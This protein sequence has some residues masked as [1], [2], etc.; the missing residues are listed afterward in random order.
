YHATLR[1]TWPAILPF[2]FVLPLTAFTYTSR[3]G[4]WVL[5]VL[6]LVLLYGLFFVAASELVFWNEF[7]VRFN[8]I[9][10]DYLVYTNEVIG[11]I[12]ESYPIGRWLALLVAGAL[13]VFAIGRRGLRARDDGSRFWQRGR[14]AL[15]WLVLTVAS[16]AVNGGMKDRT[17]N[18]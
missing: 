1:T 7:S 13:V 18:N 12:R 6:A 15:L 10:V 4:Q 2:L 8:F 11:N 14:I 9:A 3:A 17:G 5:Y 16:L